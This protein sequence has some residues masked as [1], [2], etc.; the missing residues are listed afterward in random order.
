MTFQTSLSD[1][2]DLA[3]LEFALNREFVAIE[4][5]FSRKI[6]E[7]ELKCRRLESE[8]STNCATR[9]DLE[10]AKSE[11]FSWWVMAMLSIGPLLLMALF[12]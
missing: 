12:K 1:S 8:L 5:G 4:Q 11:V 7:L 6:L 9:Q 2:S 3:D 10:R